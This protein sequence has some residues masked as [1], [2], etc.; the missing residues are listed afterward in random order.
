VGTRNATTGA[1]SVNSTQAVAPRRPALHPRRALAAIARETPLRGKRVPLQTRSQPGVGSGASA[2]GDRAT[3]LAPR[4]K[5]GPQRSVQD[6][7]PDYAEPLRLGR[8]PGRALV[9][10]KVRLSPSDVANS[11]V[12]AASSGR[13][14]S[15]QRRRSQAAA[16]GRGGTGRRRCSRLLKALSESDQ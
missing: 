5:Q 1:V 4:P 3:R 15:R 11:I 2:R 10:A 14:S 16:D 13:A 9:R 7:P 6:R 12:S 8:P